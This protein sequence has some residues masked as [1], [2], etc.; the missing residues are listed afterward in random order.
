[1][2]LPDPSPAA[3][4]SACARVTA[5]ARHVRV[6]EDAI[7]SFAARLPADALRPPS[8]DD[9]GFDPGH[10]TERT[11][12]WLLAYNAVNFCYWP[13]SGPRWAVQVDGRLHGDDDEA[14]GIMAAFAADLRRSDRLAD[15]AALAGFSA[16]ALDELLAPAP[17]HGA[18]PLMAERLAG[19]RALGAGLAGLGGPMGLLDAAEGSALRLVEL[20]ATRCGFE[21]CREYDGETLTFRKRAY[22]TAAMLYG[23]FQG[24]APAAF[25]D[26]DALPVFADYRLPQILRAEGV[27]DLDPTLS[28]HIA[29]GVQIPVS[30]APEVELRSATVWAA[31]RLRLA[32]DARFP[33][34]TALTIDH[35]LWRTAVA[36]QDELP[37]FH[38]TR[39]TDY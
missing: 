22:L 38:R 24:R 8:W 6:D 16:E 7:L 33:G 18:L 30:S 27:L 29:Q 26:I 14:L 15:P 20:L 28:T 31:E 9:P 2:Y 4:L 37:A 5:R 21:D 13:D 17:G 12:A 23:R 1:M 10:E 39:C 19:L 3:L 32:L 25:T 11:V 34:V 35:L 36:R